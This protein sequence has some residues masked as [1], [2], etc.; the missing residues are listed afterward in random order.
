M[1]VYAWQR[2]PIDIHARVLGQ[3]GWKA[4]HRVL[5]VGCGP[6]EYLRRLPAGVR[7]VGVDLSV[8][9][10]REAAAYASAAVA[11]V[12]ELPLRTA[13]FDR[14]LAPHMLYHAEDIPA[15]CAELRRVLRPGGVLLA[16]TNG[17]DHL[18]GF[19][20]VIA[21][22]M[23]VEDW[24]RSFRRFSLDD[25]AELLGAA[26]DDVRV[27][28]FEGELVVDEVDP[29]VAYVASARSNLEPQLPS[30]LTWEEALR[31]VQA[32]VAR[33]VEGGGAFRSRTHS[34]VLVCR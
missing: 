25:A 4:G 20:R 8:G 12:V 28:H 32:V 9:M 17:G 14:V 2:P 3:V 16:V 10:A 29:V 27:E 6:G 11:D 18:D 34:G 23:G 7:A 33:E 13:T 1:G 26:F 22:G 19:A 24:M 31:R 30:G 15:A 5:D 21:E